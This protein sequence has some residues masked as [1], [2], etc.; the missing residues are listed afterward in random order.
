MGPLEFP[1]QAGGAGVRRWHGDGR[2]ARV[3]AEQGRQG[4]ADG[5]LPH[6]AREKPQDRMN[7][8]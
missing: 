1:G 2:R 5:W 7:V 6:G 8:I 3:G 4:S